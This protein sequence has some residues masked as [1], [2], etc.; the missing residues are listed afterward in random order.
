VTVLLSGSAAAVAWEYDRAHA[1]VI[2]PGVSVGGID[3]GGMERIAAVSAVREAVDSSLDDPITVSVGAHTETVTPR[4]LGVALDVERRVDDALRTRGDLGFPVRVY[5]RVTGT[6]LH[7]DVHVNR[8][9][10]HRAVASYASALARRWNVA[11]VDA[12]LDTSDGFV[13]VVPS[14]DGFAIDESAATKSIERALMTNATQASFGGNVIAPKVTAD[15]LATVL[16]VRVGEN[17]LYLYRN[18]QVEKTYDV[19]TGMPRYPTPI[20]RFRVTARLKNPT[21]NNPAKYKGGWGYNMPAKIGPGKGNPLGTRALALSASGVLIHGTSNLSSIGYN[22]SHGCVR[23][24]MTD[25]EDLF[26]RVPV[27][28]QVVIVRAGADRIPGH[29]STAITEPD[30]VAGPGA[31][32][33]DAAASTTTAPS[34]TTTAPTTTTTTGIKP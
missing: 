34:S 19:A 1:R 21:W 28:T 18:G 15:D 10:D 16:L 31:P 4:Q 25:V 20:G 24:R 29:L 27:S 14:Q 33:A 5:H 11:A 8:V 9:I 7:S 26:E 2:L 6:P 22:A 30:V 23:M 3:V 17:K 12:G 13:H 32:N